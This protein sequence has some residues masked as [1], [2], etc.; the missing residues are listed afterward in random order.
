[1]QKS[2]FGLVLHE[3]S[4]V[5]HDFQQTIILRPFQFLV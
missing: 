1:M 3:I 5:S 2:D 4:I